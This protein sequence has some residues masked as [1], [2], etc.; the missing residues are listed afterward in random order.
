M[1]ITF[2][3]HYIRPD[4]MIYVEPKD[5]LQPLHQ[6]NFLDKLSIKPDSKTIL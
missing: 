5:G 6:L 1:C 4:H 2:V 3:D